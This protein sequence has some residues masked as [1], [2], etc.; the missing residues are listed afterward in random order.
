MDGDPGEQWWVA[1][2]EEALA[3]RHS[4]PEEA[5]RS[6]L[7][8]L[9]GA[10]PRSEAAV[11]AR[12]A[13]GLALRELNELGRARRE[14]E[15]AEQVALDLGLTARVAEIQSAH[16]N[17]L[18]MTGEPERALELAQTITGLESAAARGELEMR[19]GLAYVQIGRIAEAIESYSAALPAIRSGSDRL[20]E[21]RL[22]SNR[23][24][25]Y[26]YRGDHVR[27]IDDALTAERL[28]NEQSQDFLA[29]CAAHNAA[30]AAGRIGAIVEALDGF[31]RAE[32]AYRAV[33]FPGRSRGVLAADRSEVLLAA[34]LLTEACDEAAVAVASLED[35]G[36]VN[37]LAEARLLHARACAA[38]GLHEMAG[39]LAERAHEEFRAT[40]RTGWAAVAEALFIRST[41]L[42]APSDRD[43]D[44][45]SAERVD[46]IALE[47]AAAGWPAEAVS[48]RVAAA[49]LAIR[50][51][52]S[53]LA[54]RHLEA[55]AGARRHGSPHRRATAWLATARLRYL[56][57]DISGAKRAVEAGLRMVLLHQATLG[58]TELRAGATVHAGDL[59]DL[60]VDLAVL[61][62]KPRQILRSAE[63]V[64]ANALDRTQPSPARRETLRAERRR[65][66]DVQ[67]QALA[68]PEA[69]RSDA[70]RAVTEQEV[71]V[72]EVARRTEGSHELAE[73]LDLDQLFEALGDCQL[74]EFVEH[75]GR[76][77]VVLVRRR[78]CRFHDLGDLS[79]I[80]PIVDD[81]RFALS[82]AARGNASSASIEAAVESLDD[83]ATRLDARL[84][85]P[86]ALAE[87]P[88]VIVPTGRLYG[89]AWGSLRSLR[90][91]DFSVSPS[92]RRWSAREARSTPQRELR[93]IVGPGLEHAT[94]E[95]AAIAPHY[96]HATSVE[97]DEATV[98]AALSLLEEGSVVHIACHG[99]FRAD[100]PM[101]S[102]LRMADGPM[103]VFD[104]EELRAPPEIVVL[105]ACNSATTG[106]STGDELIGTAS[107]LL[108]IGVR[109]VIAPT[110]V[111]NDAATV[112]LME[113]AHAELA[114]GTSAAGSLRSAR[115]SAYRSRDPKKVAVAAALIALE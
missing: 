52:D 22:L 115:Q 68:A 30:F 65:L 81:A 97:G 15:A 74:V 4:S 18:T 41:L 104:L 114:Q 84:M 106:V 35:A 108:G 59:A 16:V 72:R 95:S 48:V 20:V 56:Q 36:D 19:K 47:L 113:R 63:F 62:G 34:G 53:K 86:L 9:D 25:A 32:A 109:S 67:R 43:N 102:S 99:T 103:T 61:G 58:A 87:E 83:C 60:G 101:F 50:A 93:V 5:R 54:A 70:V 29:G 13:N 24:N 33:G 39:G 6:A 94:A 107:A 82:R 80:T 100:S 46:Q 49:E 76:I 73:R 17:V 21:I 10:D 112:P 31:E 75:R 89:V 28:A 64:R 110:T 88:A 57:N 40:G 11:I 77:G 12:L 105:P 51:G 44:R 27:A 90:D 98:E 2:A 45:S 42:D 69:A 37:D 79:A 111:V 55:A 1:Q 38:A 14:L 92:A 91:R 66:R 71:R 85:L 3:H 8:V 26:A 7:T 78:R 96:R 23:G